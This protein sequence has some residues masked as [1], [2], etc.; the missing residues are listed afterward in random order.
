MR[1]DKFLKVSRI[2]KRRSVAKEMADQGRVLVNGKVAKSA[3]KLSVGDIVE[4]QFGN[5]ELKIKVMELLDT[6][7]KENADKM[8]QVL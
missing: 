8:Y 3:T 5:R 2:V 1:I 7:K 6:T 4:I